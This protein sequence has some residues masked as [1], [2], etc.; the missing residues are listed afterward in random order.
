MDNPTPVP[1]ERALQFLARYIDSNLPFNTQMEHKG[2]R[3]VI[4]IT[5]LMDH[6]DVAAWLDRMNKGN[7]VWGATKYG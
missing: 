4:S 2:R 1:S 3:H 5:E 7:H 6:P